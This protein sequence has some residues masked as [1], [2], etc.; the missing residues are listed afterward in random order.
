MN[1]SAKEDL[2]R[3]RTESVHFSISR[4][5]SVAGTGRLGTNQLCRLICDIKLLN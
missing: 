3:K 4:K 5:N 1:C 2:P